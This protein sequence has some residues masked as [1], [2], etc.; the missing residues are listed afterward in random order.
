MRVVL[1]KVS[2]PDCHTTYRSYESIL[3]YYCSFCCTFCCTF[4][5]PVDLCI[6]LHSSVRC[7]PPR[8]RR[9]N[10]ATHRPYEPQ[11][12]TRGGAARATQVPR[13]LFAR[14]PTAHAIAALFRG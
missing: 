1:S 5:C 2:H 8:C 10:G 4:N 11:L 3:L 6:K 12:D 13:G 7:V 9:P 14:R